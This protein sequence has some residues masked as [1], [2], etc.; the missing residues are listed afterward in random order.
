MILNRFPIL[1]TYRPYGMI[2]YL[3]GGKGGMSGVQEGLRWVRTRLCQWCC[4][5]NGM[6]S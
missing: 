5:R 4:T 1:W 3:R 2:V 6:T